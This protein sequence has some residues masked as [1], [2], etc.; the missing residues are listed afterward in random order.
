MSSDKPKK[1]EKP[2]KPV[3]AEPRK[4]RSWPQAARVFSTN[5]PSQIEN[6][7]SK[8]FVAHE[9][10]MVLERRYVQLFK[11]YKRETKHDQTTLPQR[12]SWTP[13]SLLSWWQ[14]RDLFGKFLAWRHTKFSDRTLLVGEGSSVQLDFKMVGVAM[15]ELWEGICEGFV[16]AFKMAAPI[17]KIVGIGFAFLFAILTLFLIATIV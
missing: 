4:S 1:V 6:H 14:E 5:F 11:R 16:G 2:K 8:C 12:R 13:R 17:L 9:D 10:Y 3:R 15:K 7:P